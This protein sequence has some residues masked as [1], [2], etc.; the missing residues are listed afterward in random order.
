VTGWPPCG[1]L[2]RITATPRCLEL[3]GDGIIP[4][5]QYFAYIETAHGERYNS[6]VETP[7]WQGL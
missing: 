3:L 1:K 5:C 2:G 4:I 7:V 6:G